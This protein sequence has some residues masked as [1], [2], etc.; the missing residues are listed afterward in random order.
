MPYAKTSLRGEKKDLRE[1]MRAMGIGY[2]EIAAEF[3]RAYR[4]RPRA[5]WREA[6]GWSLTEAAARINAYRGDNGLD[7]G[8]LS[9]MTAAHLC[10]YE[11]W[12]GLGD[13]LA[14]RRPGPY[15]LAVLA[16]IYGC[17]VT[18]LVDAADRARL[19]SADLLILDT[20]APAASA[21]VSPVTARSEQEE[22]ASY[23][24]RQPLAP[25]EDDEE[26]MRRRAFLLN[27][28]ILAELGKSDP[29]AALEVIRHGLGR[30]FPDRRSADVSE[31]NEIAFEYGEIYAATAPAQ[32]LKSLVIDFAML[33][34]AF[35]RYPQDAAQR[36]LYRVS[37]LLAGFLAQTVNNLGYASEA[38]R[39]W[40]TARYAA[41]RSGD[42]YSALW[43]RGREVIHAMGERPVTTVLRLIEDAERFVGGAPAGPVLELLSGKAQTLAMADRG[44]EAEDAL[45]QVRQRFD[46]TSSGGYSGSLL[47]WGEE[48]LLNT[49][50]FTYSWLGDYQRTESAQQ[51]ASALYRYDPLN[52]RWPAGVELNKA[53][54]LVRGGDVTEGVAYARTVITQ[55]P[56]AHQTHDMLTRARDVLNAIPRAEAGRPAVSEYRD[57]LDSSFKADAPGVPALK[58][59]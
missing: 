18:E 29:I 48:R 52:M 57:W 43:V 11:N 26:V 4:L 23:P 3:A 10:E 17:H 14:G 35:Q 16:G 54:C 1:R 44:P 31:W 7:P 25:D 40:R 21:A 59:D 45:R 38:R 49:E 6:Y 19:P 12:P 33:Q 27:V 46:A 28:A 32:L 50:S 37:A 24:V 55:L 56:T 13:K 30:P 34:D 41:D 8:G 51:A 47:A 15:L 5:A 20:Y 36:E 9:G 58:H 39:W 42:S 22:S 53:F 2:R